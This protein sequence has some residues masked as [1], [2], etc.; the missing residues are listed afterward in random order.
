MIEK[1]SIILIIDNKIEL[2][3][4]KILNKAKCLKMYLSIKFLQ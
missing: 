3:K 4:R 1:R 2:I